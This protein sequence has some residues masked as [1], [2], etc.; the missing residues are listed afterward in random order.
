MLEFWRTHV[1]KFEEMYIDGKP[2]HKANPDA[3]AFTV[4]T[5]SV[6][7]TMSTAAKLKLL[8]RGMILETGRPVK[9]IL[10]DKKGMRSLQCSLVGVVDI[11]GMILL[12][13]ID[14]LSQRLYR[15]ITRWIG[16]YERLDGKGDT[17]YVTPVQ[18]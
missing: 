7:Q 4:V 11:Q 12:N 1:K 5:Y 9:P 10:F 18:G 16:E 6:M 17:Q 14:H 13:W 15:S 8:Q 3:S 2:L